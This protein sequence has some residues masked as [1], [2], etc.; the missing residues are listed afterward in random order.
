M[1]P[2]EIV[3]GL[4]VVSV[5]VF[6]IYYMFIVST[7][8]KNEDMT[9][10]E[11]LTGYCNN[12]V[13]CW[14]LECVIATYS[15]GSCIQFVAE[16]YLSADGNAPLWMFCLELHFSVLFLYNYLMGMYLA[17]HRFY[18]VFSL[19]ALVD[20]VTVPP[21]FVSMLTGAYSGT[22]TAFL[23]FSRIMKIT[24]IFR[25]L[26]LFSS[27]QVLTSPIDDAINAQVTH[28]VSTVLCVI[29][30]ATGFVQFIGNYECEDPSFSCWTSCDET[31]QLTIFNTTEK[32]TTCTPLS[33]HD[34][35]YFTIVT[36]S[37]VGYGDISPHSVLGRLLVSFMILVFFYLVPNE[38]RRLTKLLEL[39][40]RY[41]GFFTKKETQQHVIIAT[42]MQS[43][44]EIASFLAEFFHEDHGM[45][46]MKVVLLVPGE[47]SLQWKE[48]LLQYSAKGRVT[49]IKGDLMNRRD[50]HRV[51]A[52]CASACFILTDRNTGSTKEQDSVTFLRTLAAQ[53]F[54]PQLRLFVQVI[55][56]EIVRH[57]TAIGVNPN[58]IVCCNEV[59]LGLL[60]HAV[61]MKGFATLL[62]NLVASTSLSEEAFSEPWERD[63]GHGMAK[64]VYRVPIGKAFAGKSFSYLCLSFFQEHDI[65]LF[66]ISSGSHI[67]LHPGSDYQVKRSDY[68]FIIADDHRTVERVMDDEIYHA[69]IEGN[70]DGSLYSRRISGLKRQLTRKRDRRYHKHKAKGKKTATH[71]LQIKSSSTQ[72]SG[73]NSPTQER[74]G[75]GK[76]KA[77]HGWGGKAPHGKQMARKNNPNLQIGEEAGISAAHKSAN[78]DDANRNTNHKSKSAGKGASA[79]ATTNAVP[80]GKK[81]HPDMHVEVG[82]EGG[83]DQKDQP[84]S[85][86][87][88]DAPLPLTLALSVPEDLRGGGDPS[89]IDTTED[90]GPRDRE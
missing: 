46:M 30:I 45:A 85:L 89:F 53:S 84:N 34:A 27:I 86:K 80:T 6:G 47:P 41:S 43:F 11:R 52:E 56:P 18:Y 60:A 90:E 38:T 36:F 58:R 39:K 70:Q 75:K 21:V 23:R 51:M 68:G 15:L 74:K 40:S 87:A 63:Y 24:R 69:Q 33:F 28:L 55:E 19:Q 29:I 16:T 8:P 20:E 4:F 42:D 48:L 59:K 13:T 44:S 71:Y 7:V 37:T 54:N 57:L 76:G 82:E 77:P 64:E 61:L 1:S 50:L 22:N 83:G 14:I 9:Y 12:S 62:Y 65:V 2:T 49:Y 73:L 32:V 25:L 79:A 5:I 81:I 35:F 88:G 67:F 3:V 26:R 10:K 78:T 17:K 66:G 31:E 72:S